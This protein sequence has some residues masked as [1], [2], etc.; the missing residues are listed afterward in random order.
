MADNSKAETISLIGMPGAGKSTL[1]AL[2]A[3]SLAKPFID[4]DLLIQQQVQTSLQNFLETYGFIALRKVE[5]NVLLEQDF[6]GAVL[7]TGGS[8]IY[9]SAAMS[10]LQALGPRVYLKISLQTLLERVD[11]QSSRGLACAP[12]T[13]LAALY[14]ERCPLYERAA[15]I[16]LE[17]DD[18]NVSAAVTA[19]CAKLSAYT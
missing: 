8:A 4:A 10:R 5:E 1:G 13:S 11:N 14:Q 17:L 2:L 9:S 6:S 19:L 15:D 3:K 7:A 16:T 12:G 18:Y